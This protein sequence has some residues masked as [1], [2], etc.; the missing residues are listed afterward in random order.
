VTFTIAKRFSFAAAHHLD[1]LPAG[2]KCA[3][4]HGHSYTVEVRLSASGLDGAGFVAD[5]GELDMLN[6]YLAA[7][8]D[9]RDLN[10]VLPVRP[11]CEGI[12]RYLCEWC[13]KNLAHGHL[14]TAV[15]VSESPATW[16]EYSP[17][18][19]ALEQAWRCGD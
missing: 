6:D 16:A 8:L 9:H 5:Y 18:K 14:L 19:P 17:D 7:S 1:G 4:V 3:R 15:R 10:E 13:H 2:H 12:A 11:S